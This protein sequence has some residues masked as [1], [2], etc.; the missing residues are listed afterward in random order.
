MRGLHT[1]G[2]EEVALGLFSLL[3]ISTGAALVPLLHPKLPV[4]GL[5]GLL[6]EVVFSLSP[7]SLLW[8]CKLKEAFPSDSISTSN[9]L[10]LGWGKNSSNRSGIEQ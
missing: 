10:C 7:F 8:F 4:R 6:L 3:S 5:K 2:V 1:S 9:K